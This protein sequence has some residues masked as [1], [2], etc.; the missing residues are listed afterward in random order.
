MSR[1]QNKEEI[2]IQLKSTIYLNVSKIVEEKINQLNND[3][4]TKSPII[5]SP[6]FTAQ[7]VEL[8]YNQ[9][10]SL[11]EDL[12]L[13]CQHSNR[14]TINTSDLL[15]FTRRNPVLQQYLSDCANNINK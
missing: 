1:Q 6:T 13:F 4:T 11:G 14:T 2:A 12:E 7:L 5:V 9:L 3:A 8:V 15:L 10:V